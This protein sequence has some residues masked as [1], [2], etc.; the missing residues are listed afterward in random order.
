MAGSRNNLLPRWN[1][2]L[3]DINVILK[4]LEELIP[5]ISKPRDPGRPPKHSLKEIPMFACTQRVEMCI[6]KVCGN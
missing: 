2:I 1:Y 3:G 4:S 6:V 5:D